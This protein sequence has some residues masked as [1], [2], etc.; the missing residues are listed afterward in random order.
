MQIR[1]IGVNK[2]W[3]LLVAKLIETMNKDY[4]WVTLLKPG[5]CFYYNGILCTFG[6]NSDGCYTVYKCLFCFLILNCK[7]FSYSLLLCIYA[8]FERNLLELPWYTNFF[9]HITIWTYICKS[10]WYEHVSWHEMLN[11]L[12]CQR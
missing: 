12:P 4:V 10:P 11:V 5:H 3:N 6:I 8:Y 7:I 2:L 9:C 1:L